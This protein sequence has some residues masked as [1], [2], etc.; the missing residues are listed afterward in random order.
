MPVV[1]DPG[2][3]KPGKAVSVYR[4]LP[5]KE[6]LDRER[7]AAASLF[8]AQQASAN[9]GHDFGLASD[10]PPLGVAWGKVR[11]RQRT[12]VRSNDV[13]NSRTYMLGHS[14]LTR[15]DPVQARR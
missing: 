15:P 14:T 2:R 12:T 13:F 4:L 3:T 8:Q 6:L 10:H 9:G 5:G 7:I 1:L 11:D